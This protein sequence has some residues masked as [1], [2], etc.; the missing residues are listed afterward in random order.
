M[1]KILVIAVFI[2]VIGVICALFF[3]RNEEPEVEQD[4]RPWTVGENTTQLTTAETT[5]DAEPKDAVMSFSDYVHENLREDYTFLSE[6][7]PYTSDAL[8]NA[9]LG[10]YVYDVDS[11][12]VEELTLVR[13]AEG[14]VFLDVYEYADGK[15]QYADSVKLVLDTM[16]EVD[17]SLK[18]SDFNKIA[19][20]LTIYPHSKARF[21]CLTVEQET[22]DGDYNAYTT[23][24]SY[25]DKKLEVKK[26]YRLRQRAGVVTLMCT[27]NVTLLY[28]NAAGEEDDVVAEYK[29]LDTAFKTEFEKIGLSAPQVQ[30][31]DGAL[32]SYKVSPVD[33][34]QLVFEF[35]GDSASATFSE[36]GFLQSF[37]LNV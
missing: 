28:R 34:A 37:I 33:N 2:V 14:G 35:V 1:K 5:T 9:L 27:D 29:D 22:T 7:T 16:N 15:V 24:F 19:A 4:E 10:M 13:S 36:N 20:R 32:T 26:S 17:F 21:Y 31:K 30:M 12:S 11:D 8:E 3:A 18:L 25:K 6:E 23:V